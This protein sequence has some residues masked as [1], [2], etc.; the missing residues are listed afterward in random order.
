MLYSSI[1]LL[2]EQPGFS[3]TS[4]S[5]LTLQDI[6]L[7]NLKYCFLGTPNLTRSRD[8]LIL[9]FCKDE[10]KN[11]LLLLLLLLDSSG[12]GGSGGS[13]S[14]EGE[15]KLK[16][17]PSRPS[18]RGRLFNFLSRPQIFYGVNNTGGKL[19]K[20]ISLIWPCIILALSN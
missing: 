12:G 10:N 17:L 18:I 20:V 4:L 7:F 1:L 6:F 3:S 16:T 14:D 19:G 9:A 2:E 5:G 11:T 8:S 13:R 15:E